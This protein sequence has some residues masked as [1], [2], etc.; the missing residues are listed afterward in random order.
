MYTASAGDILIE[1]GPLPALD[2][3]H[4]KDLAG[5]VEQQ[6]DEFAANESVPETARTLVARTGADLS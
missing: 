6:L 4:G 5:R 1:I 3:A 2:T